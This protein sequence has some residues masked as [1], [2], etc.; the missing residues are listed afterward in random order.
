MTE[1]MYY[2]VKVTRNENPDKVSMQNLE[3]LKEALA[4]AEKVATEAT[5]A[6]NNLRRIINDFQQAPQDV[7]LGKY[8]IVLSK[9]K[10]IKPSLRINKNCTEISSNGKVIEL[11]NDSL[12]CIMLRHLADSGVISI[13][14]HQDVLKDIFY[15]EKENIDGYDTKSV[16]NAMNRINK[17]T[18][19]V[20][21]VKLIGVKK[22]IFYI[23]CPIE[24][25][26]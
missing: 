8:K 6:A 24:K 19:E 2:L 14:L 21:G 18:Q 17:K 10:T 1:P 9:E 20:F 7:A 25:S 22:D 13:G 15:D 12:P 5:N 26:K 11:K 4:D 23:D 16:R 3:T